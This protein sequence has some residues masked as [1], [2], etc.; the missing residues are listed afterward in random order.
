M[1]KKQT[2]YLEEA[3]NRLF[4]EFKKKGRKVNT[5]NSLESGKSKIT[6]VPGIKIKEG[7]N[8]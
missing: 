1:K 7:N 8:G 4:K 6:F 2:N 3:T 5:V